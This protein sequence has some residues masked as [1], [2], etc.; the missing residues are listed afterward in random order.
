MLESVYS[1]PVR[2]VIDKA[3][4]ENRHGEIL[5]YILSTLII[6]VGIFAIIYFDFVRL[7]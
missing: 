7:E 1:A 4:R 5:L 3:I 2:S 6:G